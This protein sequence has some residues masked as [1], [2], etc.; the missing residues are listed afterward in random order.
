[1]KKTLTANI[2]GTVFNIEED[3]FERLQRYLASIR[4]QFAGSPGTAEIMAD[5]ESRIAEL[6][7]Q[8]LESRQVVDIADVEH[9]I[10]VMG[11]PEDILGEEAGAAGAGP[12]AGAGTGEGRRYRR[13]YRDPDDRWIGGVLGGIAAYFSIDPL[14]LRLIYLVALFM[15]WGILLYIILWIVMPVASSAAEKLE[16]RGEPVTVDNIKRMFE[17]GSGRVK[18]GAERMAGEAQD[19][20]RRYGPRAREGARGF[21]GFLG[22]MIRLFL[23]FLG[24]LF[25][26]LLLLFGACL[27]V[28]LM[29]LLLGR[30]DVLLRDPADTGLGLAALSDHLFLSHGQGNWAWIA[31]LVFVLVPVTGLLYAGLSLLFDVKGPRWL[32]WTLAPLWIA[33]IAVLTVVGIQVGNDFRARGEEGEEIALA[34]P[35]GGTLHL[36]TMGAKADAG[37][38]TRYMR[39]HV[40]HDGPDF[41][42]SGDSIAWSEADLDIRRSPDSLYHLLVVREARGSAQE[43][44][45]A[46]AAAIT[47]R[48]ARHDSTLLLDPTIRFAGKIREQDVDFIVLVP[49]HGAVYIGTDVVPMLDDV[50]NVTNTWDRDMG[51]RTWTMTARGLEDLNAPKDVEKKIEDVVQRV[52]RTAARLAATVWHGLPKP[53]SKERGKT[54]APAAAGANVFELLGRVVKV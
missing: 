48:W 16:M 21:F 46:R 49:L 54:D 53:R 14:V 40:R 13:L 1:M 27:V 7:Q 10:G 18:A 15:G 51:G 42:L 44:A 3:A 36:R 6:F 4:A 25:G 31:G 20:G 52:R 38:S 41:E 23:R 28:M 30:Y 32:G 26:V 39:D 43:E 11:Q 8:R 37:W 47:A 17:E 22:E 29:V 2:G 45:R 34:A 35:A 24:R 12:G 9:V 5:I 50:E 19:L 33:S